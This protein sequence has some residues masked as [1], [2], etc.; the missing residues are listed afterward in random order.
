MSY[1]STFEHFEANG[2]IS[3]KFSRPTV[4]RSTYMHERPHQQHQQQPHKVVHYEKEFDVNLTR[5][6]DT[7]P[8]RASVRESMLA[9]SKKI[10][11][12]QDARYSQNGNENGGDPLFVRAKHI[13]KFPSKKPPKKRRPMSFDELLGRDRD[14]PVRER[15]VAAK[16]RPLS[17][18]AP[19]ERR[20][21][22]HVR[23]PLLTERLSK[24]SP[25]VHLSLVS[26]S[27]LYEIVDFSLRRKGTRTESLNMLGLEKEVSEK[28]APQR[29][30][31]TNHIAV[32]EEYTKYER[33]SD[34]TRYEAERAHYARIFKEQSHD[35][36]HVPNDEFYQ[37][38]FALDKNDPEVLNAVPATMK[39]SSL[40]MNNGPFQ[41]R[42]H[43]AKRMRL[44]DPGLGDI[45][46]DNV[47]QTDN[48]Y[49]DVKQRV[50]SPPPAFRS[51]AKLQE[52]THTLTSIA[53]AT[54]K[55]Q[56]AERNGGQSAH[57]TSKAQ[58]EIRVPDNET[59]GL[60][61]HSEQSRPPDV[62]FGNERTPPLPPIGDSKSTKKVIRDDGDVRIEV[63]QCPPK[64]EINI[65]AKLKAQ[66]RFKK[67][68]FLRDGPR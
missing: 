56:V 26:A 41:R 55:V 42:P 58:S 30:P 11:S 51:N 39:L 44:V 27:D 21:D 32:P 24:P 34:A 33:T 20:S 67:L 65:T 62:I 13:P 54:E 25:D 9:Y 53:E 18:R 7:P 50:W 57:V 38:I 66:R 46:E 64:T 19:K 49:Y 23:L 10:K 2:R 36:E 5:V 40:T 63:T 47:I 4:R 31:R 12:I 14:Q 29:T 37:Q 61:T 45:P 1:G 17:D 60:E 35:N 6:D 48:T 28:L 59:H 68:I 8:D 15:P 43:R 16:P 3:Q 52:S 22:K